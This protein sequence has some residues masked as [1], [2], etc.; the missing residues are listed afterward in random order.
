MENLDF[1]SG[2]NTL[3]DICR[4]L[5]NKANYTNREKVKKYSMKMALIG[6]N[7]FLKRKKKTQIIVLY[8]AKNLKEGKKN[9]AH[10]LVQQNIIMA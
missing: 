6:K 10:T 1:L 8:V 2:C 4:K 9:F 3:N 7:G 5:F